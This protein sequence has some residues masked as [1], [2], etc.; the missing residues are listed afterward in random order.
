MANP[1]WPPI[2]TPPLFTSAHPSLWF[3][4]S[5]IAPLYFGLV[6]LGYQF[7]GPDYLVQDDVRQHVVWL[8]RFIDPQLFPNDAIADYFIAIAPPGYKGFYWL[9]A[10][11][12]VAPLLT[13]KLLPLALALITTLFAYRFTLKILPIPFSG[14]LATLILNQ[15]LW[16]DDELITATPRAFYYPLLTAFLYCLAQRAIIPCL[17][18][19]ALQGLFYAPSMLLS[20]AILSVRLL[21]WEAWLGQVDPTDRFPLRPVLWWLVGC[22]VGGGILFYVLSHQSDLGPTVTAAAMQTMPEFGLQGRHEYFGVN[23]LYFLFQGRSG[24]NISWFPASILIGLTLPWLR[25][26]RFPLAQKLTPHIA[27]LYQT[28]WASL[29]LYLLAHL[30]LFK[31]YYP[32]RYTYHSLRIALAVSA[33]GAIAILLESG[34]AWLQRHR[35]KW[36]RNRL[37]IGLVAGVA[38]IELLVPAAPPVALALQVWID[39]STPQLYRYLAQQPKDTLVATFSAEGDNLGAFAQRSTLVGSEFALAFH[40][41]YY[42]MIQARVQD[43]LTA[44]YSPDPSAVKRVIDQYGIDFFLVERDTFSPS[45]L[46]N[47]TWLMHSSMQPMVAKTIEQ[48]QNTE[49]KPILMRA[50]ETCA[51]QSTPAWALVETNCIISGERSNSL[52]E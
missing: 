7:F 37:M 18:V 46:L 22:S 47:Q 6:S 9:L 40:P 14:F 35:K 44:Q 50:I 33:G 15:Q 10:Q 43:L 39:G 27:T 2:E 24:L 8:Q 36:H 51:R 41:R 12:G 30:F 38:A 13:A 29:G 28:V 19:I 52:R 49:A 3:K 1:R 32:S 42:G 5:F 34:Y 21:P 45:Y 4:L 31:L 26:P 17:I 16:L 48:L 20:I 25:S 11:L 23:P